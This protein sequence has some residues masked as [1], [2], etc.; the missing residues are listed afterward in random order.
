MLIISLGIL[1]G[2]YFYTNRNIFILT[3]LVLSII[4]SCLLEFVISSIVLLIINK[5]IED[6]NR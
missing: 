2:L 1:I 4:N 3:G 5:L 6:G